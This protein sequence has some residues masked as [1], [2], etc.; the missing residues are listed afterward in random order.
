MSLTI[1]ALTV[2][3]G[4][5]VAVNDLSL[6]VATGEVVALLGPSGCGKSTLLRTIAGLET[7]A[8]GRITWQGAD[9]MARPPHERD[10]G[11]MFQNHALFAHR[12]VAQNIGFGPRMRGATPEEQQARIAE[13]LTLVGLD[14]FEGRTVTSL[15][16]GEAQRVAL[17]RALAPNPSLLLLDE[18]LG[19]LDRALRDQLVIELRVLLRE[20]SQTTIHVTHDQDE[21]FAIADRIAIM[22]AGHLRRVDTPSALWNDPQS[23]FVA[24]F[25]GHPIS[26]IDGVSYAIAPGAAEIRDDQDDGAGSVGSVLAA[27][28]SSGLSITGTVTDSRFQGDRFAYFLTTEVGE[29]TAFGAA[30]HPVGATLNLHVPRSQMNPLTRR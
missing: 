23:H 12:N 30:A 9:L 29:L 28:E 20:L 24:Q 21:A 16:G 17:A 22:E 11:L 7:P 27:G 10:L 5:T 1:D 6:E 3:F 15:S 8:A 19:A 14:G 25:L 18:P 26:V 2:R 13:L 4:D